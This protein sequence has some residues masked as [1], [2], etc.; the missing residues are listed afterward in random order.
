[1]AAVSTYLDEYIAVANLLAAKARGLSLTP[2]ER[3]RV[4]DYV[5]PERPT[6]LR[7][8]L[9]AALDRR[10][11]AYQLSTVE[12]EAT[13]DAILAVVRR[14]IETL[15]M[16]GMGDGRGRRFGYRRDDVLAL[17]DGVEP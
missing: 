14:R 4:I 11:S 5:A 12:G 9:R 3:Q 8:E 15:P 7:E 13:I 6:L 10:F 17:F 1:M 16:V 2:D